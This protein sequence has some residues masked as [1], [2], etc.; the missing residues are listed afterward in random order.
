M[1]FVLPLYLRTVFMELKYRSDLCNLM[2]STFRVI[3]NNAVNRRQQYFKAC[4]KQLKN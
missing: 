1:F 4:Y 3:S 2:F